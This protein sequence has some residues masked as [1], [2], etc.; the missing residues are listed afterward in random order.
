MGQKSH[1][2]LGSNLASTMASRLDQPSGGVDVGI[3]GAEASSAGSPAV[4]VAYEVGVHAAAE[5][6]TAHTSDPADVSVGY[7]DKCT[8]DRVGVAVKESDLAVV[9]GKNRH[10]HHRLHT[11]DNV[12]SAE[13]TQAVDERAAVDQKMHLIHSWDGAEYCAGVGDGHLFLYSTG[14]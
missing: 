3:A 4:F 14:V 5:V 11:A 1:P 8:V 2:C 12:H 7:M 13:V 6:Y 9:S 10:F